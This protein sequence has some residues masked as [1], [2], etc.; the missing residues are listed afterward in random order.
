MSF[1]RFFRRKQTPL[2]AHVQT[3]STIS[4]TEYFDFLKGMRHETSD[5]ILDSV[6]ANCLELMEKYTTTGQTAAL[7]KLIFLEGCIEKER[8]LVKAGIN[9]FVYRDDIEDFIEKVAD[10]AVKIT[11][12]SDYQRDVPDEIVETIK[13]VGGYFDKL[14]VLFTDYT[15]REERRVT[16]E[17]RE[18]DPILFGAFQNGES[19]MITD[20]FYYLGDW[21][22]E[23]CDL[24]LEKMVNAMAAK[25]KVIVR[26]VRTP[27]DKEALLK[28]FSDLRGKSDG[29]F[30]RNQ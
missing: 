3:A 13:R 15:G 18:K 30:Y 10:K 27:E 16:Q 12:L 22:D 9:T 28:D 1:K 6:R 11:T 19:G 8:A 5:E 14:Y 4:P 7:N 25:G 17:R 29:T 2:A 20:R 26:N 24:T 23:F 21:V